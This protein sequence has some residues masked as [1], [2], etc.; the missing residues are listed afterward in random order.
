MDFLD[1]QKLRSHLL[2]QI[3]DAG[4]QHAE[5]FVAGVGCTEHLEDPGRTPLATGGTTFWSTVLRFQLSL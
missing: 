2:Q 4:L 5:L 3:D 1:A